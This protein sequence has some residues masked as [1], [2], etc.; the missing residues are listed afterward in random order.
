[1]VVTPTVALALLASGQSQYDNEIKDAADYCA[2]NIKAYEELLDSGE[3][4]LRVRGTILTDPTKGDSQVPALV[5]ACAG[6]KHP[7][8]RVTGAKVFIDGVVEGGTAYL[9]EP[10]ANFIE[11][12]TGSI[13]VGKKADMVV[14]DRNLFESPVTE[15]AD[16]NV[17]MTLFEGKVVY[18]DEAL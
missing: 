6:Q 10:Y 1:M 17:L 7:L 14:L 4:T 12:E 9:R 16:T 15:I 5:S 3:M 18:R 11:N 2:N 8:F 13:E